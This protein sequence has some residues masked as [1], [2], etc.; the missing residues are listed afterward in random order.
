VDSRRSSQNMNFVLFEGRNSDSILPELCL[1]EINLRGG[2]GDSDCGALCMRYAQMHQ[3]QRDA[4]RLIWKSLPLISSFCINRKTKT[5]GSSDINVITELVIKGNQGIDFTLSNL[6]N[7]IPWDFLLL[8]FQFSERMEN[9]ETLY[10]LYWD[11]Q[12]GWVFWHW[13]HSH[14]LPHPQL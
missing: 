7:P 12:F 6:C 4:F 5:K 11:P 9:G 8:K 13:Q 14:C 1:N 10:K 2:R 3:F